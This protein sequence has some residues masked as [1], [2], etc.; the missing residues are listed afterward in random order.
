MLQG[1]YA[2]VVQVGRNCWKIDTAERAAVI[3]DAADYYH[4]MREAM[5]TAQSQVMVLGWDFD[6]RISLE[7]EHAD[8]QET[9]GRFFLRLVRSNPR[10]EIHVLKWSFGAKKQFLKPAAAWMLW[11]WHRT[12]RI[13]FKFDA[14]HPIG[15][16]HHQK[17]VVIDNVLAVCGGIDIATNRWDRPNHIDNNPA[18]I[19][20][21]GSPFPPWH[22]VTFAMLGKA[23][24][25]LGELGR[26][27]WQTATQ[28]ELA[29]VTHSGATPWPEDLPAQFVDIDVAIARTR[30]EHG[31]LEQIR[32]VETLWLDMIA[33]TQRFLYVE[34]QYL[35][36][37]KIAGAI[38][39][40]MAEPNPPEFV[41]VMPRSADGWL[42]QKAMDAARI[43][44]TRRIGKIDAL[45]RFRIYV[46][47]NEARTDIY[48]HAKV[49]IMDDRLLR[50]GSANLNN[51]SFGLDSECDVIVDAALPRNHACTSQIAHVRTQLM[52]EHLGCDPAQVQ[53]TYREKNRLIETIEFLRGTGKTLDLLDL[54]QTSELDDFIAEHE[55]LDPEHPDKMFEPIHQR[56]IWKN[57]Q[58]GWNWRARLPRFR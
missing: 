24:S 22:D 29:H 32:E 14:N 26:Q 56:S 33:A 42:E 47:V 7:P 58:K 40:R 18:R 31:Q 37:A 30:A 51:R 5:E 35:T 13:N 2:P 17:I 45:N 8:P 43:A 23:A 55:L 9:L 41:F 52:A 46:P 6:T 34:N 57:W 11:R 54:E 19:N 20:P 50:I 15:C 21:D 38:A 27:R 28:C 53:A 48:V 25:S 36:S 16:S 12:H 1:T 10:L 44:L 39:V 3:I 49:A 4:F